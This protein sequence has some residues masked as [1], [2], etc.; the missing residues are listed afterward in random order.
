MTQQVARA[1]GERVQGR[2]PSRFRSLT[3][4]VV[5]AAAAGV[6]TYRLLR[7]PPGGSA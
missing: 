1:A 6:L 4:A 5:V 3:A 2:Q 7:Q